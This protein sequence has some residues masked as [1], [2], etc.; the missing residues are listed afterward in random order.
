MYFRL[1][2]RVQTG[3]KG[4]ETVLYRFAGFPDPQYPTGG[5]ARDPARR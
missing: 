2:N 3:S 4:F 1:R 5:I